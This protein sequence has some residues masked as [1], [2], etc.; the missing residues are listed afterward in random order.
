MTPIHKALDLLQ[1]GEKVAAH[2]LLADEFNR[3]PHRENIG[4]IANLIAPCD[5]IPEAIDALQRL[6]GN[7]EDYR[8]NA[9]QDECIGADVRIQCLAGA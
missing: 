8:A 5:M 2:L 3:N 4:R 9:P 7:I 6:Q 1:C